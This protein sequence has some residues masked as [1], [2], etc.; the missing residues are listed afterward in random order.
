MGPRLEEGGKEVIVVEGRVPLDQL[1]RWRC[2]CQKNPDPRSKSVNRVIGLRRPRANRPDPA[3]LCVRELNFRIP[4]RDCDLLVRLRGQADPAPRA[5]GQHQIRDLL[6][7][8]VRTAARPESNRLEYRT[9]LHP[10]TSRE[11]VARAFQISP[12]GECSHPE[13]ARGVHSFVLTTAPAFEVFED[14]LLRDSFGG[15]HFLQA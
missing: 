5:Q 2:R 1:S 6:K 13:S 8:W 7:R 9:L 10:R 3:T 12:A 11:A 4:R 15:E 14:L